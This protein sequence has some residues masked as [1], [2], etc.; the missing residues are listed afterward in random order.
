MAKPSSI[1][2]NKI[3]VPLYDGQPEL[4]EEYNERALDYYYGCTEEQQK[5]AAVK[6]R[7]GLSGKAYDATRSIPHED[8]IK[9]LA[10][11]TL[12]LGKIAGG[13]SQGEAHTRDGDIR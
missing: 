13:V 12:L 6:L 5:A 11:V 1:H 3:G 10:G 4:Q 9:S 8:L 7:T 2:L